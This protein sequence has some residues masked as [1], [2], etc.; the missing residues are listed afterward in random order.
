MIKESLSRT[1]WE[2]KL[3]AN[4]PNIWIV[5]KD[6]EHA[7]NPSRGDFNVVIDEDDILTVRT[8]DANIVC[9]TKACVPIQSHKGKMP[10]R[11]FC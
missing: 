1:I 8:L 7:R 4:R 5:V 3:W 6:L 10:I 2:Q 11:H 9:F